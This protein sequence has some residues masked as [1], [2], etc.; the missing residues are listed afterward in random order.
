MEG[1]II[2]PDDKRNNAYYGKSVTPTD[3]LVRRSVNNPRAG[4]LIKT[5]AKG[6]KN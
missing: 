3:I 5:V 6:T 2:T 4:D 1:S